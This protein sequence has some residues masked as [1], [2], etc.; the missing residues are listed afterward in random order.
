MPWQETLH[1][2]RETP[3]GHCH[4]DADD[5]NLGV[6]CET[7]NVATPRPKQASPATIGVVVLVYASRWIMSL[8]MWFIQRMYGIPHT[9]LATL[10]VLAVVCAF[11]RW[12]H[13]QLSLAHPNIPDR[14]WIPTPL[15][16]ASIPYGT[17]HHLG[18][19]TGLEV[20]LDPPYTNRKNGRQLGFK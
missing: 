13:L 8:A 5:T 12:C 10:P 1:R 4:C 16:D 9:L 11:A 3:Q 15:N 18:I 14:R 6:M 19:R 7:V 17:G 20:G 2:K